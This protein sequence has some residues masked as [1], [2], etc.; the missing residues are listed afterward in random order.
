MLQWLKKY[1][2]TAICRLK[3]SK[4]H[5]KRSRLASICAQSGEK[6]PQLMGLDIFLVQLQSPSVD[7][8]TEAVTKG[9]CGLWSTGKVISIGNGYNKLPQLDDIKTISFSNSLC[10]DA[11]Q[12]KQPQYTLLYGV[13]VVLSTGKECAGYISSD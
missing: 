7:M 11:T 1:S 4:S 12:A 2:L 3:N 10:P 8:D 9:L 13:L 6:R 5:T